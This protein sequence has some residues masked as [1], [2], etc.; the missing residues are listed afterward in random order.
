MKQ[1]NEEKF[2]FLVKIFIVLGAVGLIAFVLSNLDSAPEEVAFSLIAFVISVAAVI[3]T[4]LQ[5]VSIAQQIKATKKASEI[6]DE[7][8]EEVRKLIAADN[9][10]EQEIR[11]DLALDHEIVAALEEVGIGDDDNER[12]EVAKRIS[13]KINRPRK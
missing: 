5:S 11:E 1:K 3:M 12:R 8:A 6:V 9:R 4:T 10:M 2:Y 13:T 7:V